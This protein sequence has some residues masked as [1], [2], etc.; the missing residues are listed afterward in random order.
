M[1]H[2]KRASRSCWTIDGMHREK[3]SCSRAST[4][5]VWL[6]WPRLN[7]VLTTCVSAVPL[8]N[9]HTV[10]RTAGPVGRDQIVGRD[11]ILGGGNVAFSTQERG[12]VSFPSLNGG[13][14]VSFPSLN[15]GGNV[16]SPAQDVAFHQDDEGPG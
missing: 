16:A 8:R 1:S 5:A 2:T 10:G 11:A 6:P 13:G 7:R 9:D 3:R 4:S 15:G 14:N 12:N